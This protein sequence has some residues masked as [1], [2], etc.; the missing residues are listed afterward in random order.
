M[1]IAIMI[2][3]CAFWTTLPPCGRSARHRCGRAD[4][5]GRCPAAHHAAGGEDQGWVFRP[6]AGSAG[7]GCEGRRPGIWRR[8]CQER[9]DRRRGQELRRA[10]ERPHRALGIAGGARRGA[11]SRHARPVRLRRVFHRNACPMCQGRSLGRIRRVF[12]ER[13]QEEGFARNS[14]AKG[15]HLPWVDHPFP[16][17]STAPSAPVRP[18]IRL[19]GEERAVH[20]GC[21]EWAAL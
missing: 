20:G 12:N 16:K 15:K 3:V 5:Y 19:A 4:R 1:A 21:C 17:A 7:P 8:R 13:T 14:G 18:F 11:P 9:L 6:G 2:D 10:A